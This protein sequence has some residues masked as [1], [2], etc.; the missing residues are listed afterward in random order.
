MVEPW[1]F[2]NLLAD[3]DGRAVLENI[4]KPRSVRLVARRSVNR[5]TMMNDHGARGNRA[6]GRSLRIEARVALDGIGFLCAAIQAV[7]K[8]PQQMRTRNVRHGAVLDRT[9]RHGDPNADFVVLETRLAECFILVPGRG[10]TLV[11]WFENRVIPGKGSLGTQQLPRYRESCFPI[12]QIPQFVRVQRGLKHAGQRGVSA[13]VF[14]N[15]IEISTLGAT[16]TAV[17]HTHQNLAAPF[18][19]GFRNKRSF[20]DEKPLQKKFSDLISRKR[21]VQ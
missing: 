4:R 19:L 2:T 15:E 5:A 18:K 1:G 20:N 12:G 7:R 16:L 6:Y 9:I 21:F 8:H 17:E 10:A 3:S 11:D 14:R 13:T